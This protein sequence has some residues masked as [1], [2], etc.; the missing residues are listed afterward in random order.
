M[1]T[2]AK[3]FAIEG[4]TR[5]TRI[6]NSVTIER[7]GV[8]EATIPLD[9]PSSGLGIEGVV[10]SNPDLP[11]MIEQAMRAHGTAEPIIRR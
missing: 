9:L 7:N 4:A 3:T 6:R 1:P 11:T 8:L 10:T 5:P 2:H